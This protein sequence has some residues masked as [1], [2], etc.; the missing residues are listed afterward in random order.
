MDNTSSRLTEENN[1]YER[2]KL[3]YYFISLVV[4]CFALIVLFIF[5]T[6]TSIIQMINYNKWN[7]SMCFIN[8]KNIIN[9]H[10][11]NI[12]KSIEFKWNVSYFNLILNETNF[13][14]ID[15]SINCQCENK[16]YGYNQLISENE[17]YF[18]GYLVNTTQ[19]C[20]FNSDKN[21]VWKRNDLWKMMIIISIIISPIIFILLFIMLYFIQKTK[22]INNN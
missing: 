4:I 10:V 8:D 3:L 11:L 6:I 20:F 2:K 18:N 7:E 22:F 13:G 16:S 9:N 15:I 21:V 12:E 1:I 14:I 19:K 17:Q 5:F